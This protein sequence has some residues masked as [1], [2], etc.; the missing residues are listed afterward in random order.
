MNSGTHTKNVLCQQNI[1]F[2]CDWWF[3]LLPWEN[4]TGWKYG[5]YTRLA[6]VCIKKSYPQANDDTTSI[7]SCD[8]IP[9]NS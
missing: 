9:I 6:K 8:S 3:P 4:A 1:P 7:V 5:I 2:Y